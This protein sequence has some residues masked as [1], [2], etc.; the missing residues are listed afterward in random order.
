MQRRG[1]PA[2]LGIAYVLRKCASVE[3]GADEKHPLGNQAVA[4]VA[5]LETRTQDSPSR[6][7]RT[8]KEGF[9]EEVSALRVLHQCML[10]QVWQK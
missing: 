3:C 10:P 9:P 7:A 6:P 2:A 8:Q 4:H 5:R 1:G